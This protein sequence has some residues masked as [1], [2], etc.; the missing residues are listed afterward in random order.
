M[1]IWSAYYSYLE[2]IVSLLFISRRQIFATAHVVLII[3]NLL[4]FKK[5]YIN[6]KEVYSTV[7]KDSDLVL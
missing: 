7:I 1:Y 5:V 2:G 3:S 6:I 4:F